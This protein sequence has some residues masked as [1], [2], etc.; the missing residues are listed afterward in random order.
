MEIDEEQQLE[1]VMKLK[2]AEEQ[3]ES[4]TRVAQRVIPLPAAVVVA[5]RIN[6]QCPD[7]PRRA[8]S[9]IHLLVAE[10]DDK[11]DKVKGQRALEPM[12]AIE[13]NAQPDINYYLDSLRAPLGTL[14]Y[15]PMVAAGLIKPE[16]PVWSPTPQPSEVYMKSWE[17]SEQEFAAHYKE[18]RHSADVLMEDER[19]I[20]LPKLDADTRTER[21]C[22][23]LYKEVEHKRVRAGIL[24]SSALSK[25]VRE[26]RRCLRC[27]LAMRE[28]GQEV[29]LP[30]AQD[31]SVHCPHMC[32]ACEREEL[33][34]YRARKLAHAWQRGESAQKGRTPTQKEVREAHQRILKRL[35]NRR[36]GL[37]PSEREATY[38]RRLH[39]QEA[40]REVDVLDKMA[41]EANEITAKCEKCMDCDEEGILA[42]QAYSCDWF[43]KRH[44]LRND[45]RSQLDLLCGQY[46]LTPE[47]L[48]W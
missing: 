37:P 16:S 1:R 38:L 9:I 39:E 23:V 15:F 18:P 2:H 21:V 25:H 19:M 27:R 34:D 3:A 43:G 4:E 42:C 11:K 30:T 12:E 24:S 7:N 44:L 41:K 8:G 35:R 22:T 29:D 46:R 36:D 14:F 33:L 26:F 10:C 48:A 6:E 45:V 28:P 20:Q 5:N 13:T 47:S 32:V 40:R 17:Q 31:R